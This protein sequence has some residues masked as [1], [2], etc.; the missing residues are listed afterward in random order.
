MA[1]NTNALRSADQAYNYN[2][3]VNKW[4][5]RIGAMQ[6]NSANMMDTSTGLM[7]LYGLNKGGGGGG[8]S[9]IWSNK[10]SANYANRWLTN[11]G[12]MNIGG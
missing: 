10:N 1:S 9:N 6:Q 4:A 7:Y 12:K 3:I 2:T 8:G 5:A 11:P